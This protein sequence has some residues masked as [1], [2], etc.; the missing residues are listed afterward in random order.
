L[1]VWLLAERPAAVKLSGHGEALQAA[2]AYG[3]IPRVTSDASTRQTVLSDEQINSFERSGFLFPLDVSDPTQAQAMREAW[4]DF[5]RREELERRGKNSLYNL[6]VEHDFI[7]RIASHPTILDALEPLIGPNI[8]LF[9]SRIICKWGRED[10]FAAWHQDLSARN[11]LDPPMQIT[12]WYAIDDVDPGNACVYCIPG[13]H[14]RGMLKRHP[15]AETGNLLRVNEESSVSAEDAARAVAIVLR[16]GQVS[17]HDGFTLHSSGRNE[18]PRRRCGLVLRYVPAYV[19][20]GKDVDFNQ[21]E[22][23]LVLRGVDELYPD[24]VGPSRP[25]PM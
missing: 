9:A 4:D 15:A 25:H 8:L 1:H 3:R 22:S 7:W 24:R 18:S 11:Q 21:R 10:S 12:A 23:A 2:H 20:Q 14:K 5:E 17:F 6:H 13:S 19:R 16:S